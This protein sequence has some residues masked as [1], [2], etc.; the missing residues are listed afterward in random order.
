MASH[1]SH[2]ALSGAG[3]KDGF[4]AIN[5]N[6][7][8]VSQVYV[9]NN[10]ANETITMPAGETNVV[11]I[12]ADPNG[13]NAAPQAAIKVSSDDLQ[14]IVTY[15]LTAVASDDGHPG[16]SLTYLWAFESLAG[17]VTIAAAS[18]SLSGAA[19]PWAR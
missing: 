5:V 7:E 2:I 11:T 10:E 16:N 4:Y 19:T 18:V 15:T 3:L 13:E 12:T 1:V 17:E 8:K 9:K 6:G 14:A